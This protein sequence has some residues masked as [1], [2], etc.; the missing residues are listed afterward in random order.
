M[1]RFLLTLLAIAGIA[2]ANAQVLIN[3]QVPQAGLNLKSQLWNMTLV[4]TGAAAT[5]VKLDM[6]LSDA[7]TGQLILSGSGRQFNLLP[8]VMQV[9]TGII[10]PIQYNVLN[11]NYGVDTDPDG[12]LPVGVYV[13]C[14][15]LLKRNGEA[16]DKLAE[17]C[18]LIEVEPAT[19]PFLI[20]PE[21]QGLIQEDRPLFTWLP[22]APVS[23]FNNLSY[24]VTLVEVWETQN[25]ASA[26]QDNYPVFTQSYINAPSQQYPF[27][28]AALDT[29]KLYA[30]QVKALS[31]G[32][33]VSNSEVY[34]FRVVRP[35][36]QPVPENK[37]YVR[38]K[39]ENEMPFTVCNGILQY[40][41]INT[42]NF[43]AIELEL[44]DVTAKTNLSITL[45]N[46]QQTV[47]YGQNFLKLDLT[48]NPAVKNNH[49]Y[50]FKVHGAG[51]A[52][53]AV[54]FLYK[55]SN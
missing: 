9:S 13:V 2:P 19:P 36:D 34:S 29:G 41:F 11:S 51:G 26:V 52:K 18:V 42:A 20:T 55:K 46:N 54:R 39:S 6:A 40:E 27:S 37:L 47:S 49:I 16:L 45:S 12:F 24:Q 48:D 25:P 38:L 17:D 3:L 31:N 32:V 28:Y 50:L 35:G 22:P 53:K 10:A 33:P 8:G 43:P 14:F 23:L 21:D 44:V 7:T 15:T 30:W 1:K 5:E 4:N